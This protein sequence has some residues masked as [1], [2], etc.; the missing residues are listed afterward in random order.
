MARKWKRR[1]T[2]QEV[3]SGSTWS[4]R[5][6]KSGCPKVY[7]TRTGRLNEDGTITWEDEK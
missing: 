6:T 5:S 1:Q 3:V 4:K 2:W 7:K